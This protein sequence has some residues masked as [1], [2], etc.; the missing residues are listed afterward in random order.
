VKCILD[1]IAFFAVKDNRT[2]EFASAPA[3]DFHISILHHQTQITI[4][5]FAYITKVTYT[6]YHSFVESLSIKG[7]PPVRI[8]QFEFLGDLIYLV[9][10]V[11][12]FITM[13]PGYA[14]I[15]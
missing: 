12:L 14:G 7:T 6:M 11:G 3:G 1:A 10:T 15:A 8:G 2:K 13:N 9:P 5:L 4:I